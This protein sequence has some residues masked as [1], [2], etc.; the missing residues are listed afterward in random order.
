MERLILV[1]GSGLLGAAVA[2]A[3]LDAGRE[4]TVVD[5]CSPPPKLMA[6]GARWLT[7]DLLAEDAPALPRGTVVI[8]PGSADPPPRRPWMLPVRTGVAT[9]RLLPALAGRPVLLMSSVDIYGSAP[10]PWTERTVPDLPWSIEKIDQW[11]DDAIRLARDP[12]PPWRSA[13]LGRRMA[14]SG[15]TVRSI[16]ALSQL[17]Q[18]RL[19][20]RAVAPGLLTVLRLANVYGVGTDCVVSSLIGKALAGCPLRVPPGARSFVSAAELGELAA[21]GLPAGTYNVGGEPV[22]L[23]ALAAEIRDMCGSASSV[24]PLRPPGNDGCAMIDASRLAAAGHR[25]GPL[26]PRLAAMVDALRVDARPAF[27]PEL[28]VVIPPRAVFPDQVAARQQASLWSG[29]V[30]HGNRWSLELRRKLAEALGAG[31]GSGV[32]LTASGTSALRLAIVATV[33]AA[34]PGDAAILPSF[35]FPATAEV[36]LQLGYRL[37]FADVDA[38]TWTMRADLLKESLAAGPAR[39]VVCVDTFGNPCDYAGLRRVC[40]DAGVPLVADSAASLGSRYQGQPVAAQA[41]GHAFSMSFAKV[42]SAGGAGGAAVLPADQAARLLGHPAGWSR[43]ELMDE[44]HA[45]CALDQ[46]AVLDD[47]VRRRNAIAAIYRDGLRGKSALIPQRASAVTPQRGSALIPQGVRP[48]D[49]HSYV[50]WVMR[51]PDS[52]G[53]D[54]LRRALGER[55]VQTKPYFRALHLQ[56]LGGERLP[57]TQR[58]DAEV[59]ALPMSSELTEHEAEKV[60]IAVRHCV[61]RLPAPSPAAT[62]AERQP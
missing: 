44:L 61:A 30:K 35:T 41:D 8:L 13:P 22:P 6:A 19:L 46:L 21:A 57:V 59:L 2:E 25:I 51:V 18:E 12:C 14:D 27:R 42:L 28:P 37:R 55:G 24:E 32:L 16:H 47:L 3:V 54:A 38:D 1:G 49:T 10:A 29:Q 62:A 39:V 40:D 4:V 11:C 50:H 34:S 7:A 56:R 9:A 5:H 31:D 23:L 60:V 33:G 45:I 58:L 43:S 52:L 26:R 15:S 17:A 20:A 48:G 36:L 53:R